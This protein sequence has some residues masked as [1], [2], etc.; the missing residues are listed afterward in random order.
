M[1]L[2]PDAGTATGSI[3]P[4]LPIA[5]AA[6]AAASLASCTLLR[7]P[8]IFGYSAAAG[9]SVCQRLKL[10]LAFSAGLIISFTL[11]GVAFQ[12]VAGLSRNMVEW[13]RYLYLFL[14]ILLI[15]SGVLFAGLIPSYSGWIGDRCQDL[16]RKISSPGSSFLFGMAFAV[17]ELPSCP[18]CGVATPGGMETGGGR[19]AGIAGTGAS[20]GRAGE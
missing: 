6:G 15:A 17:L 16:T 11:M 2:G 8:V 19:S 9:E 10:S 20:P 18:S 14:G 13:S 12:S 7:L 5:F 3:L 4:L 1:A